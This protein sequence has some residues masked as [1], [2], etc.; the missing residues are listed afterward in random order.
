MA[1]VVQSF[2]YLNEVQL[3]DR[4]EIGA[5]QKIEVPELDLMYEIPANWYQGVNGE[6]WFTDETPGA[7]I[8]VK[9]L[10]LEAPQEPE[11][12]LLPHPSRT[13][14]SGDFDLDGVAG[15]MIGL[16]TYAHVSEGDEKAS[17]VTVETHVIAVVVSDNQR[18]ALDVYV[19]ADSQA[20]L[21]SIV[22]V[23]QHLLGTLSLHNG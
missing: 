3:E 23:Y 12:V 1:Q 6:I 9:W 11:A 17:V 22:A 21:E 7:F 4:G 10:D 2:T 18:R 16:E 19:G 13:I 14:F 8:G 15:R 20:E 5:Y